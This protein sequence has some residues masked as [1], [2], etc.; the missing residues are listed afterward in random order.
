M[1]LLAH[2]YF[3][4]HD[5]KQAARCTPYPP[6]STLIA[7]AM[8][9]EKGHAVGLFDATFATDTDAFAMLLEKH[10]PKLV[11]IMEDNFNFLTKMC[12]ERRQADAFAMIAAA[13]RRGIRI[14]VNGP[15]ATDRPQ[16]YLHAGATAILLGEGEA[17]LVELAAAMMAGPAAPLGAIAGLILPDDRAELRR[18]AMRPNQ[19]SLDKLPLPAWDLVNA[20]TYRKAWVDRHGRL[21]WNIATSRGC[22]YACNWCA[23]PI[24]G[25]GYE[26]RSPAAV[27]E[28][29][30]QLKDNV[31]P[32]HIWFS[33][34]IFG[35]T[36]GWIQDFAREVG[37]RNARIPFMMQSRVN[38]MKPEAVAALAN[39]GAEE[40]WLGVESGSQKILDAM[41]KGSTVTEARAATRLLK[42]AGI[43]ACWFIQLGYPGETWEDL[44]LTR[45]LIAEEWPDDIG[46]S[47]AYPLPGTRFHELVKAGL[48]ERRNWRDSDD[49]AMLFEGTYDTV[50]YRMV[51]DHLHNEARTSRRDD[52]RWA[53]LGHEECKHRSAN[54]VLLATG[55]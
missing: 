30:R 16:L 4:Y 8:L 34:D 13:R 29:I 52:C 10:P 49:L 12:T 27:A 44:S 28:E 7:A 20:E 33:D 25:R 42:A 11:A 54:P 18:T 43:R 53:R 14:I 47:V 1:I 5:P 19:R 9:R 6:L 50:F 37:Q 31:A 26:Q 45:K 24:F 23:K 32:D 39:A 35:L 2:S 55:S 36:A 48:G 21:S 3:M 22:P 41:E 40:V 15:D 51:R 46:V 17:A 38:L